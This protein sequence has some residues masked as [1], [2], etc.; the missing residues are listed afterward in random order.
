MQSITLLIHFYLMYNTTNSQPGILLH[1]ENIGVRE[2][3]EFPTLRRQT[4][5]K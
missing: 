4:I 3:D 5:D 2:I 1:A